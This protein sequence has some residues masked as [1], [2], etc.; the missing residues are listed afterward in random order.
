MMGGPLCARRCRDICEGENPRSRPL[1][2]VPSSG[3]SD[4]AQRSAAERGGRQV[5]LYSSKVSTLIAFLHAKKGNVE[6][7]KICSSSLSQEVVKCGLKP[8]WPSAS[9]IH[10]ASETD[11]PTRAISKWSVWPQNQGLHVQEDV[12]NCPGFSCSQRK[13]GSW[14]FSDKVTSSHAVI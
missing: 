1:W 2:S 6:F 12:G 4:T 3:T 7:V 13:S 10:L 8:I 14:R 5:S 11:K 9:G